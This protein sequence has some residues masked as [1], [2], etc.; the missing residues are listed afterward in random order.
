MLTRV[1]VLENRLEIA[2]GFFSVT[3]TIVIYQEV[4]R[5]LGWREATL[6][7]GED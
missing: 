4:E 2:L 7:Q 5:E 6:V 3:E 1:A